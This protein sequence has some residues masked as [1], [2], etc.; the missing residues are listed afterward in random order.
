ME[1]TA[2]GTPGSLEAPGASGRPARSPHRQSCKGAPR[3]PT[4]RRPGG[5]RSGTCPRARRRARPWRRARPRAPVARRGRSRRRRRAPGLVDRSLD[6]DVDVGRPGVPDGVAH[7]LDGDAI[8][9]H[10]DGGG[11][12]GQPYA[13]H[14]HRRDVVGGESAGD[15]AYGFDQPQLV[16]RGGPQAVADA[17]DLG[18]G[19]LHLVGEGLDGV[20][21]GAARLEVPTDPAQAE[22]DSGE[23]RAEA[24][25]QVATEPAA[26]LLLGADDLGTRAGRRGEPGRE[27]LD[28]GSAEHPVLEGR[29][30]DS[31]GEGRAEDHRD[32]GRRP[33]A[34]GWQ[35]GGEHEEGAGRAERPDLGSGLAVGCGSPETDD[36]RS[37]AC[38]RRPEEEQEPQPAQDLGG[39]S[40]PGQADRVVGGQVT[41]HGPWVEPRRHREQHRGRR[42][43]HQGW[44]P[45]RAGEPPVRVQQQTQAEQRSDAERPQ[46]RRDPAEGQG[47]S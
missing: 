30:G 36:Q 44:P 16:E 17:P 27:R 34:A 35:A 12:L 11:E 3:A 1:P 21:V 15:L 26:F 19:A 42:A 7:G 22:P 40:A 23:G 43:G 8:G 25:V 38:C 24:V 39:G 5:N 31:C 20:G 18:H 29:D 10:L 45:A 6:R 46:P 9:R 14:G 32:Q 33:A 41:V 4:C 28:S 2:S 47:G 37:H 13:L